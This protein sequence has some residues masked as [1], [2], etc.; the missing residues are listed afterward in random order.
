MLCNASELEAGNLQ[1][2]LMLDLVVEL[3]LRTGCNNGHTKYN[4][5]SGKYRK[6]PFP[7]VTSVLMSSISSMKMS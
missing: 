1:D 5:Q 4:I 3:R 7:T 6:K 2:K